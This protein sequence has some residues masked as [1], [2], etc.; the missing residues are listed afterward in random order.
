MN[1]QPALYH[2]IYTVS[3]DVTDISQLVSISDSGSEWPVTVGNRLEWGD[4]TASGNSHFQDKRPGVS[5][6]DGVVHNPLCLRSEGA[7]LVD[8]RIQVS[9]TVNISVQSV[10]L[11]SPDTPG[12]PNSNIT[13]QT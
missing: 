6:V 13:T 12:P 10:H 11:S 5:L 8:L 4:W 3:V 2:L 9:V 7:G 1:L